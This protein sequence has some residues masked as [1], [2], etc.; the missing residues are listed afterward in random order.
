MIFQ[1]TWQQVLD[2][3]KTQSRR[4]VKPNERLLT[5]RQGKPWVDMALNGHDR[6]KWYIGQ[7]IAVQP[8]RGQFAIWYRRLDE[9]KVQI[10]N[11]HHQGVPNIFSQ[12]TYS[13]DGKSHWRELRIRI[14]GIRQERLQDITYA[15][16]RRE[17]C[18]PIVEIESS[19]FDPVALGWMVGPVTYKKS[20]RDVYAELWDAIHTAPGTRWNEN[21]EVWVLEFALVELSPNRRPSHDPAAARLVR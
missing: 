12:H 6:R 4:L 1:H 13:E 2:G 20:S 16:A 19:K 14:T 5:D 7:T 9:N 3:S 21:P 15:D 17:G 18:D 10:W 11:D 8:G